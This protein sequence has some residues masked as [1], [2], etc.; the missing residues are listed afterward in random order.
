MT[1]YDV[2]ELKPEVIRPNTNLVVWCNTNKPAFCCNASLYSGA[3]TTVRPTVPCGTVIENG[4]LVSSDTRNIY[5]VGIV[6]GELKFGNYSDYK[7]TEFLSGY[8]SPVQNGKYIAP[9]YVD[10]YV[11]NNN[12]SRIGIGRRNNGKIYVVVDDNV[13]LQQFAQN[14]IAYGFETLVNLDGG[15]S[16]CVYKDSKFIYSS[17][18]IPYNALAFYNPTNYNMIQTGGSSDVKKYIDVSAHQGTIDFTKLKGNVDGVIIRAGYGKNNID[19]Q[20]ARNASECNR[21]GIPCGAYW[22]SY[23][24]TPTMAESEAKYLLNAVKPYTMELPLAFDYEYDSVTYGQKQ[25]VSITTALV[26]NMTKAF[27]ETIEKANYWCMLYANPDFINR[28]FGDLAGTRF[29]LWLAQ[30]PITFDVNK[31]PRT[32][33]IW[34]Y[35]TGKVPGINGDVDTNAAYK[36]YATFLRQSGSNNLKPVTTKPSQPATQEP[37]VQKPTEPEKPATNDPWYT[38]V[39]Q[40]AKDNGIND[41]TRPTETATRAEVTQMIYNF[42][43]RFEK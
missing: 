43:T 35:G 22:F 30:W 42:Y 41:G 19:G 6:D 29:D 10:N 14:A 12:L 27:C 38:S 7:W 37:V 39:M 9:G 15:G 24:Y 16:R 5:G 2:S 33:G 11:F 31:P 8:N 21:L 23:A 26:K 17:Y 20:F 36:D 34:Q 25:G 1:I 32:C 28:Y 18:R 4:K 40:W 13:T 3:S